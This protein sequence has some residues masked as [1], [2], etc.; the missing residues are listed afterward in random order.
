MA[1]G[2]GITGEDLPVSRAAETELEF[3]PSSGKVIGAAIAV[4]RA[5]GPGF[6]ESI[7]QKAMSVELAKRQ[8]AFESQKEI[9]VLYEGI[10]VGLHRLDLVIEEEIIVELKAVKTLTDLHERQ[11]RSYLKASNLRVGLLLNFQ[12]TLLAIRRVVN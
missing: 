4:H 9:T 3:E 5:L 2:L 1:D 7:Y 12:A 10:D 11:L 6:I 8:I